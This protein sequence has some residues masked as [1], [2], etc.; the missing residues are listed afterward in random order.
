MNFRIQALDTTGAFRYAIGDP[1][2]NSAS[3]FRPKGLGL[4]SE[5][6]IYVVDSLWSM[7]QVFN[8]EG[9]LLYYFGQGGDAPG[10][11][12]L[13][14]GLFIDRGNEIYVV[15]SFN[16]RVQVFRY[17]PTAAVAGGSH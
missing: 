5:Q 3:M 1:G 7:V 2:D 8:R 10:D 17:H 15:D 11:F 9:Q 12:N 16:R 6:N 13:P 4:D 14:S